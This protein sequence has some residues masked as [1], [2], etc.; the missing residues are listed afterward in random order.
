M[1]YHSFSCKCISRWQT[2]RIRLALEISIVW[3]WH[4]RA[5]LQLSKI[6]IKGLEQLPKSTWNLSTAPESTSVVQVLMVVECSYHIWA[7]ITTCLV[8][9]ILSYLY[10]FDSFS[11]AFSTESRQDF[12]RKFEWNSGSRHIQIP[13]F[14][15]FWRIYVTFFTSLTNYII[16]EKSSKSLKI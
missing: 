9:T 8:K 10:S 16:A 5:A 4:H 3:Y 7:A 15:P 2:A 12:Q 13:Q 6:W 14:L 11:L 1:Q